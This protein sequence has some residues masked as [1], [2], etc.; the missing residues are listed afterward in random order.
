MQNIRNNLNLNTNSAKE[1]NI[2]P[3]SA[4]SGFTGVAKKIMLNRSP[5]ETVRYQDNENR[6]VEDE[7]SMFIRLD[8]N[9]SLESVD[10]TRQEEDFFAQS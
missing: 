4:R 10:N 7:T 1:S 6:Q 9:D 8:K 5:T 2:E 3:G